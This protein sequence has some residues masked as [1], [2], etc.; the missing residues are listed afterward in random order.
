MIY[1]VLTIYTVYIIYMIYLILLI[2]IKPKINN[3]T[4][5]LKIGIR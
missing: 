1:T 3:G 5:E 2:N 4:Q